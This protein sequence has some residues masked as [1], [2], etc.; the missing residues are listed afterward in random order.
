MLKI[1][2]TLTAVLA[3]ATTLAACGDEQPQAPTGMTPTPT[4]A[5]TPTNIPSPTPAPTATP[6][7]TPFA[8]PT[9][10]TTPPPT[11]TPTSA[12]TA[13]PVPTPTATP[14]LA[15]TPTQTPTPTATATPTPAPT[16]TPVPTPTTV[17]TAT[18][19]PPTPTPT[20]PP[21]QSPTPR[22]SASLE[23]TPAARLLKSNYSRVYER[24]EELPW[25]QDSVTGA[26]HEAIEWLYW[27]ANRNWQAAM[28]LLDLPWLQDSITETEAD[29][30]EWLYWLAE[31]AWRAVDEAI[32]KP[33]L[34]TLEA[35]DVQTIR[36]ITGRDSES[37]LGRL[38]ASY[39]AVAGAL[40]GLA[41]PQPPFTETERDAIR[42]LYWLA[43]EDQ[44]TAVAVAT[45]PW[46]QDGIIPAERAAIKHIYGLSRRETALGAT[47]VSLPWVQDDITLTESRA[48]QYLDWL[49]YED[50][51]VAAALLAMPWIL[52]GI[53]TTE[54]ETIDRIQGLS[55]K[56]TALG[57]TVISLTWVQDDITLTEGEA[58]KYLDWLAY[59][60]Q[61]V[62]AT[63]IAL[64]WM[65]DGIT[66]AE[67]EALKYLSWISDDNADAAAALVAMPFLES[68]EIRDTL[69]LDSLNYISRKDTK[70]FS[71]LMSY[72]RIK[73][74]ITDED[75]KIVAVLGGR[76][77][78]DAPGSAEVLLAETGVYVQERL[79]ELPHTGETLLAIIRTQDK[80]TPSMDY[81]EHAVRT[82]EQFMGAPFPIDYLAILFY[83]HKNIDG[84][85]NNFTHLL[86]PADQDIVGGPEWDGAASGI[87]HETA[88]W[89]WY[90]D[91]DRY[92]YQNWITEGSA[93]FLRVISE[94]E[95]V[96]RPLEPQKGPCRYFSS[97]SELE[98][99]NPDKQLPS[100]KTNPQKSCYYSLGNRFF[101]DLYLALGDETFRPAYRTLYLRAQ[102]D[103]PPDGCGGPAFNICRVEA[104]FKDGASAEVVRKVDEV[105]DRW[106]YGK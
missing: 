54:S 87:A 78:S 99:A 11:H 13:T 39:T 31:D 70:D 49:A 3:L 32:A 55:R 82:I 88:H 93:D 16:A 68:V 2:L 92:Q 59:D 77:Y 8:A 25:T 100:G 91:G 37:Y 85:N 50:Q 24:L 67:A 80:I 98:K 35:E 64:P 45:M 79:I 105:I 51:E 83:D 62:A 72:P 22:P 76:T 53:T 6:T 101:L 69:A 36:E 4:V 18:P 75:T 19:I 102:Q 66:K 104:A 74:G 97:I 60:D 42:R 94:H 28:A 95:R 15:P 12:P 73:D 23:D 86:H 20:R 34:K 44:T 14:T 10:T 57:P 106:Y 41:W 21:K 52:D 89:Y 46:V 5:P 9:A 33:F 30:I 43:G 90:N 58:I 71:E 56:E 7:P 17:P 84:K 29:A 27:L 38:S 96:G 65:Q 103:D 61:K 81:F 40:E 48:I 26:E 1:V 63:L 47:V